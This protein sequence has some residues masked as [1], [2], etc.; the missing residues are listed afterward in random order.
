MY[1]SAGGDKSLKPRSSVRPLGVHKDPAPSLFLGKEG[2]SLGNGGEKGFVCSEGK[3]DD[4]VRALH[5]VLGGRKGKGAPFFSDAPAS[6]ERVVEEDCPTCSASCPPSARTDLGHVG[7][8]KMACQTQGLDAAKELREGPMPPTEA[9]G[10]GRRFSKALRRG[11][12]PSRI[13]EYG[14]QGN[15]ASAGAGRS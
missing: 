2:E 6:I 14:I 4:A 11:N 12:L 1:L 5:L 7:S 15:A 10:G 13:G 9:G 8:P 3:R